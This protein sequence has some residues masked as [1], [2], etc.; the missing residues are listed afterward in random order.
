[1]PRLRGPRWWPRAAWPSATALSSPRRCPRRR[2]SA[3]TTTP[4]SRPGWTRWPPASAGR[5]TRRVTAAGCCRSPRPTGRA[6]RRPAGP[7]AAGRAGVGARRAWRTIPDLPPGL[8]PASGPAR[9]CAARL[10][11]GVTA[12]LED[13]FWLRPPVQLLRDPL[14]PRRVRVQARRTTCW[15]RPGGWP[16][17]GVRELMLVSENSTSYGK[18]LGN[19]RLLEELLPALA[20]VD[21]IAVVRVSYLQPAELRPGL[22]D[23]LAVHPRGGAVLRPVVPARQRLGA[24]CDA[25]V[26][27]RGAVLRP[28]GPDQAGLPAGR[29]QVQLH[30]RIPRRDRG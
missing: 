28:A 7:V 26:R 22:I 29:D 30:R 10:D 11:R 6:P 25:A 20:A 13:R 24:A 23:V 4:T 3:S 21:G 18:D 19:L 12:P 5:R 17:Q 16:A 14:V 9:C 27:R 2:S 8:A 1:M 15:P